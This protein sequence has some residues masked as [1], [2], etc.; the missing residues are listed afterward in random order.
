MP[1]IA[2]RELFE[3]RSIR[4]T[5]SEEGSLRLAA[6]AALSV[7]RFTFC[8]SISRWVTPT[9]LELPKVITPEQWEQIG[10]ELNRLKN[11]TSWWLGDWWAFGE[12]KYGDRKAVVESEDWTGPCFQACMDAATVC[13]AFKTS[14]RHEVLTFKHHRTVATLPPEQAESL[15]DWCEEPLKS[16]VGKPRTIRALREEMAQRGLRSIK[17]ATLPNLAEKDVEDADDDLPQEDNQQE[18]GGVSLRFIPRKRSSQDNSL[19]TTDSVN[20]AAIE[21]ED[22]AKHAAYLAHQQAVF[23]IVATTP[24]QELGANDIECKELLKG[25]HEDF[26]LMVQWFHEANTLEAKRTLAS[27]FRVSIKTLKPN[28]KAAGESERQA[29]SNPN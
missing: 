28:K 1:W 29:A 13:R 23:D 6:S 15:L 8:E 2:S 5:T 16:G 17:S 25:M 10:R 11:A 9:G 12:H 26:W 20:P 4:S 24:P 7:E 14:S 18:S 19:A 27:R 21:V 22:D 3:M